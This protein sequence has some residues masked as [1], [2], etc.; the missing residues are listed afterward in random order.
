MPPQLAAV[1]EEAA[2]HKLR[3]CVDHGG[4]GVG[5]APRESMR[6]ARRCTQAGAVD[7]GTS[8]STFF[9]VSSNAHFCD[10]CG[11]CANAHLQEGGQLDH[12]QEEFQGVIIAAHRLQRGN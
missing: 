8:T 9:P 10:M 1:E 2:G 6:L 7:A 11:D 12:V 3:A 4:G 5:P